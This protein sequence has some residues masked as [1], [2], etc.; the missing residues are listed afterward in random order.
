MLQSEQKE[1]RLDIIVWQKI[2]IKVDNVCVSNNLCTNIE[3]RFFKP[4]L[5]E[6]KYLT[7]IYIRV[8]FC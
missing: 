3:I 5:F 6:Q 8:S 7:F 4:T 1:W 2:Q